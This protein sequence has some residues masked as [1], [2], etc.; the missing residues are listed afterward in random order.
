MNSDFTEVSQP[1]IGERMVF[2]KDVLEILKTI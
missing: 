1:F 2:L